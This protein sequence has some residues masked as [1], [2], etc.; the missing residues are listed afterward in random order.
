M[1]QGEHNRFSECGWL[2]RFSSV[3][4]P[5][6]SNTP[7][8]VQSVT[9]RVFVAQSSEAFTHDDDG[10][11]LSDG[12]FTYTWNGQNRLIKAEEQVCPTNRTLRKVDY[13]Y[14]HQG[15]MVWKVVSRRGAEAQ[16]WEAEKKT[17]YLWEK[18]NI[19][20]E[21][22]ASDSATN[23]TYN[24]WGL[25]IDGSM[26]GAGG[27]G[28]LLAV[29]KDTAI[30][31]PAWD[32][33]GNIIEYSANEG[34][35]VAHREY[36]PFGGTVVYTSQSALTNQQ[37]AMSFTHWF[38]TKPWCPVT[39]LSEY[40]YRKY[41]PAIGRWL[42][43]D[44]I[45]EA[46]GVGLYVIVRNSPVVFSDMLGLKPDASIQVWGPFP[47]KSHPDNYCNG[48]LETEG[49]V[50]T[51]R[52]L[53]KDGFCVTNEKEIERGNTISGT[54]GHFGISPSV[55]PSVGSPMLGLGVG[56]G[57]VSPTY[58]KY[59]WYAI[60]SH[61][62]WRLD[63]VFE[64]QETCRVYC[65]S[66]YWEQ[67]DARFVGYDLSAKERSKPTIEYQFNLGKIH[68]ADEVTIT[69]KPGTTEVASVEGLGELDAHFSPSCLRC[70]W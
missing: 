57:W 22:V 64:K 20:A 14:D 65:G 58:P 3:F 66:G 52:E 21:T 63:L 70:L 51:V 7:D 43:W 60:Y 16:S 35:I 5:P 26:Q 53:H 62:K 15:R 59:Q 69:F 36:D 24:I 19:I 1:N 4:T 2:G 29:V 67:T 28:G 42:S 37:S 23:V 50:R 33:N 45:G 9:G 46:G 41:S 39:G 6:G 68:H 56:L 13:A 27:V 18:F 49:A 31:I 32:A 54:P 61:E 12:R 25:D 34:T 48:S 11:M 38:S 10:N 8:T 44:P 55:G 47:Y 30:Y 17:S 40:Q